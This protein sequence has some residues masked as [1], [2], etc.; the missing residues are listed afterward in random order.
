[1]DVFLNIYLNENLLFYKLY[2]IMT[3]KRLKRGAWTVCRFKEGKGGGG[4][5]EA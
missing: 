3:E 5:G 1:M 4:G 2:F